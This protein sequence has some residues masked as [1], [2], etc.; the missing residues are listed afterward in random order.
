MDLDQ[1]RTLLLNSYKVS[2]RRVREAL[3]DLLAIRNSADASADDLLIDPAKAWQVAFAQAFQFVG[4]DAAAHPVL[5]GA[6]V[7]TLQTM[8]ERVRDE[9]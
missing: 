3:D 2:A 5:S 6:P 1:A 9:P 8:D 4:L 7:T